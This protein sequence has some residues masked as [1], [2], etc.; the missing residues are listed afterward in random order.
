[1][2]FCCSAFEGQYYVGNF[3]FLKIRYLSKIT[4]VMEALEDSNE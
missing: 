2:I 4:Q 1:M 3:G